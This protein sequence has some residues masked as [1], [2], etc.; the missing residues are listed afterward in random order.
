MPDRFAR[1]FGATAILATIVVAGLIQFANADNP[2]SAEII[3]E[4]PPGSRET[5]TTRTPASDTLGQDPFVYRIG[6]LQGLSTENFWEYTAKSTSV[7]DSYV[8][9]PTKASLFKLDGRTLGLQPELA[10][11][12]TEPTW[13]ENGWRVVVKL[14]SDLTWSDGTAITARDFS[15]TFDVVRR[16]NLGGSWAAG[17]PQVVQSVERLDDTTLSIRFE[18]RPGLEVWPY[19]LGT[20]PLMAAHHWQTS[21]EGIDSAADLYDLDGSED[22]ASGPL[23]LV[24]VDGE[25]I[26]S[27][28]NPGYSPYREEIVEYRVYQ[29]EEALS[30][31]LIAGE[32]H[33]GLTPKGVTDAN[34]TQLGAGGV[35]TVHTDTFGIRYLGFNLKRKPMDSI[36]FRE[37]VAFL[38]DRGALAS[39][40]APFATIAETVM[41]AT[42]SF[43]F[44]DE[45]ARELAEMR[46]GTLKERF[47]QAIAG[48]K[49]AGYAW[50]TDPTFLDGEIVA[51]IGLE[52]DGTRPA[53]LTILTPGDVYDPARSQYA[54]A[55]A[56]RIELLGFSVIPVPT[57]FSTVVDLAFTTDED[58]HRQYDM[59]LL[60]WSLGNPAYPSFYAELFGTDGAANNTGYSRPKMDRLIE[61]LHK[62]R[63]VDEAR[64][65]IWQMEA[66]INRDLPYLPLYTAQITEAYRADLVRLDIEGVLGG[67]HSSLGGIE[68]ATP[69]Q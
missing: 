6:L 39:E 69:V 30:E 59:V 8:L 48:L 61:E 57:D 10:V 12:M 27:H 14:R 62:A 18:E 3:G 66:L 46:G 2:T 1:T 33:T 25:R 60:G 13:N 29:S 17:F 54:A 49:D 26:V 47:S 45:R 36:E 24:E 32:V 55:I 42:N 38:V 40:F 44:D 43:W 15:F 20:V 51:G 65:V 56:D 64:D 28:S 19:A 16:L 11:A 63:R 21:I 67:I 37:A 5:S 22:V 41:P 68:F 58:G 31:A 9:A 4:L 34:A 52:I 53:P 23:Q 35:T 50:D 7:W